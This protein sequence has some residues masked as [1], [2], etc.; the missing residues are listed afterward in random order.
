MHVTLLEAANRLGG[1]AYSFVEPK[2]GLEIDNCQHVILGCCEAIIGFLAAIGSL[3]LVEF[4]ETIGFIGPEGDRLKVKASRLPAPL[5]LLPSVLGSGY[6]ARADRFGL[7]RVMA[8]VAA[9]QAGE[10]Y[11]ERYLSRIGCTRSLMDR[12][13]GPILESA[14][15][16]RPDETSAKYARMVLLKSLMGGRDSYRL[17]VTRAPLSKVIEE[18]AS[19]Y[20]ASR[21][22]EVRLGAR[23]E[24]LDGGAG[25]I[26]SLRLTT[27]EIVEADVYVCAVRPG[28]LRRMGYE[29]PQSIRHQ[30][31]VRPI[32][33]VHL[34]F[35]CEPPGV[36][37]ACLPGEP[38]GW[39]F[40]KSRDFGL[41]RC[42]VQAVASA[43][44]ELARVSKG[45]L[46]ALAQRAVAR[47]V[48]QLS[49]VTV[50]D[51]VVV[52]ETQATFPT[53]AEWEVPRPESSTSIPNLFL[54]GDWTATGWP[55]TLE[56]AAISGHLAARA[57]L[58]SAAGHP[59]DVAEHCRLGP[60]L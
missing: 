30:N 20:F 8:G 32:V 45:D 42:Y 43:A 53:C 37:H 26:R 15:N 39:V 27:G 21:G 36:V 10:E 50:S 17:G 19:R 13:I 38:F 9:Q 22:A 58:G 33:A 47:A 55:A 49:C 7:M 29:A 28:G 60:N 40:S 16:E 25:E 18:P 12:L 2:T 59:G 24:A 41:D 3:E 35:D 46:V 6:L 34:F 51:A 56:G 11:A 52:W 44:R 31:D 1:R 5:H 4:R 23:V 57:A 48:P 14:L 54:A